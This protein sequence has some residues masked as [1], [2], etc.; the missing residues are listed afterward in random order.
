MKPATARYRLR[1]IIVLSCLILSASLTQVPNALGIAGAT[2]A[3]ASQCKPLSSIAANFNGT[4][5]GA[6][7]T[8]W[9]SSVLKLSGAPAGAAVTVRFDQA[10]V[11]YVVGGVTTTVAA[12]SGVVTFSP[13]ATTASTSYDATSNT[14]HSTV[15]AGLGGNTFLSGLAVPLPAGL[16]GGVRPVT[17]SGHFSSDTPG[18]GVSWQWAAAAYTRFGADYGALGVKPVDD[19]QASAY[20][21]SDHAGTPE[22]ERA[23]VTG[24]AMGGGGAN[25]TGSYSGTQSSAACPFPAPTATP[26]PPTTTPSAACTA[27]VPPL[28]LTGFTASATLVPLNTAVTLTASTNMDVGPTSDY[29]DIVDQFGAILASCGSGSSCSATVTANSATTK[30]YTAYLAQSCY[31]GCG[32]DARYATI[33]VS[34]R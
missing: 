5:L 10:S 29:I 23:F 9:F 13:A 32:I 33:S 4:A 17:W 15:P 12:P 31:P 22:A 19:P 7:D 18:V 20:P 30:Q 27:D 24:G 28:C 21:N 3:A 1:R 8:L 26:A 2:V 6:G 11:S 34:W 16:P 25:Y 14:W